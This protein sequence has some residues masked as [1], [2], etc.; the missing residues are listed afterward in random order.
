MEYF[1]ICLPRFSYQV[2]TV[3]VLYKLIYG[4]TPTSHPKKIYIRQTQMEISRPP[5]KNICFC[6]HKHHW[7]C[8]DLE[9]G[10]KA[11][12]PS[13]GLGRYQLHICPL[14][15]GRDYPAWSPHNNF[16]LAHRNTRIHLICFF[17]T[18]DAKVY[19]TVYLLYAK[20]S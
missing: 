16:P 1:D 19:K 18:R 9:I 10:L 20:L 14:Q 8:S 5:V 6:H 4:D 15:R 12:N 3:D 11:Q 13:R 17:C 7:R 2:D